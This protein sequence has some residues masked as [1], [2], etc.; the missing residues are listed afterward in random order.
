LEIITLFD[1]FTV[2]HVSRDE[3]IVVNDLAQQAS[4]FWVNQEKIGFLEKPDVLVY[5]TEH[6]GFQ[7]VH[8]ATICSA[9]PNSAESNSPISET[10]GSRIFRTLDETSK[11]MTAGPDDWRAPLIRYLE[12]PAHITNKKVR[13][14]ALNYVMLDNTLYH[15]TIDDLL[16]K[17]L[18]SNQSKVVMGEVHQ[19][20]HKM[21][22]LLHC[23]GFYWLTMLDDCFTYYKGCE[24]CQKF[25]N[26]QLAHAAI[27]HPI[28]KPWPFR[29]WVLDFVGQIH[30]ASS[31][32]HRFVLVAMDYF[33]KW[34]EVVP[35]KNMSHGEVIHF[36]LEHIVHRFGIP[37][38][39]TMDQGL[40]FMS[41]QVRDFAESLKIKLHSSSPYYAQ[42]NG[43]AE[44]SNKTLIKLIKKK[45]EENPK[46]WHQVLSKVLWAHHI[47][48]HSAT[49]VKSFELVYEQDVVL[50]VEVK[51]DALWIARQNELSAIDYHNLMLDRLDEVSDKRVKALGEI[52][53]DK[54]G[55]PK[56]TIR[57]SRKIVSGWRSHLEDDF[58]Y[59]V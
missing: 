28:I 11:T 12:N 47:S 14:Q 52:E 58:A 38:T 51:M 37:Q 53:R 23:V 59:W 55:W 43:Q 10:G 34:T 7:P 17:Y 41:H 36:I 49:K 56:P 20:A 22:W 18:G 31:K 25:K 33:T 35:L 4:G 48:K 30:P 46:R 21:K 24:S 9:E 15:R 50:P 45:I 19:S 27:L 26:V 3:N 2:Q 54:L 39:L 42:T 57:E 16:L 32:G 8:S 40:S 13:Q 5:Q 6:S 44:S 29:S 1:D